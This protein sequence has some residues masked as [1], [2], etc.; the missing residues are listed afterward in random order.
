MKTD[1]ED[2][3]FAVHATLCALVR[4]NAVTHS[5]WAEYATVLLSP[6]A[7]E[8]F[9]ARLP[10]A[11]AAPEVNSNLPLK[12]PTSHADKITPESGVNTANAVVTTAENAVDTAVV[13][14]EHCGGTVPECEIRVACFDGTTL[15]LSVP[16]LGLVH[17]VKRR[18]G[19]V[20]RNFCRSIVSLVYRVSRCMHRRI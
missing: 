14:C 20:R 8:F 3:A 16:Q 4:T 12:E 6:E 19:Q 1:D 13:V 17:E 15:V 9:A 2:T 18:I 5:A 7:A 11:G 10:G